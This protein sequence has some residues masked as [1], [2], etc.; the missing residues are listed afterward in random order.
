MPPSGVQLPQHYGSRAW[1]LP[2]GLFGHLSPS[3]GLDCASAGWPRVLY[4]IGMSL[5]KQV[6][7]RHWQQLRRARHSALSQARVSGGLLLGKLEGDSV[8]GCAQEH[9]H[10]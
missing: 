5:V 1:L 9:S 3:Q 6:P 7:L 10:A 4:R 8:T 2:G